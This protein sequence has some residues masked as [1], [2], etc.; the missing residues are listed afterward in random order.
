MRRAD[1][2]G[3]VGHLHRKR[4]GIGGAV[5]LDGADAQVRAPPG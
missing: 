1:I 4:L 3:L 5:R 2:D